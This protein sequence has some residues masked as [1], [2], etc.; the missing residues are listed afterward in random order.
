MAQPWF[1]IDNVI[2]PIGEIYSSAPLTITSPPAPSIQNREESPWEPAPSALLTHLPSSSVTGAARMFAERQADID[3]DKHTST[4]TAIIVGAIVGTLC[5][6][7]VAIG[8]IWVYLK[9][10]RNMASSNRHRSLDLLDTPAD[11]NASKNR[12]SLFLGRDRPILSSESSALQLVPP[13]AGEPM[14]KEDGVDESKKPMIP[15]YHGSGQQLF[16]SWDSDRGSVSELS[17]H[18]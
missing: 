2:D 17:V 5:V 15:L 7:V 18:A 12:F 6:L 14:F 11:K 4:P 9:R 3:V 13:A 16:V 1:D 8:L 10:R